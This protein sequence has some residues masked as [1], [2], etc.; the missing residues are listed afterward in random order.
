[1]LVPAFPLARSNTHASSV[2]AFV[3]AIDG[4]AMRDVVPLNARALLYFPGVCV[5]AVKVAVRLLPLES[6]PFSI[7]EDASRPGAGFCACTQTGS[8]TTKAATATA[9]RIMVNLRITVAPPGR[10][11]QVESGPNARRWRTGGRLAAAAAAGLSAAR[12]STRC[13]TETG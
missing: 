1:S 11:V 5:V 6:V 10:P 13:T 2:N 3:N 7:A 8:A 4:A 9:N 12:A